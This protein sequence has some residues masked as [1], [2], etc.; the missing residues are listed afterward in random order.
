MPQSTPLAKGRWTRQL[1]VDELDIAVGACVEPSTSTTYASA[2]H[3][4]TSFCLVH[5]F[6]LTPTLHT[7]A[8]YTVYMSHYINPRSVECYLSGICHSL[9]AHYPEI[10]ESRRHPLVLKALKGCKKLRHINVTRK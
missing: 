1:L 5:K 10:R 8:F 2:L 7:L 4:Y 3:S 6:P 9:E